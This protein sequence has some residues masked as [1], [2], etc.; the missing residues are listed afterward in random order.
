VV[1]FSEA[2][3]AVKEGKVISRTGSNGKWLMVRLQTPDEN[4]KMTLPYLYSEDTDGPMKRVP[5]S[6]SQADILA[7]DWSIFDGL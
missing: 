1:N 3:V 4:S 2:L 7:D 5:W 6:P